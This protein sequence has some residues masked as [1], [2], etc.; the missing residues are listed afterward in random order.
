MSLN[1]SRYIY[2][3]LKHITCFPS[4][5]SPTWYYGH[6]RQ[7]CPLLLDKAH[8]AITLLRGRNGLPIS[9]DVLI[10]GMAHGCFHPSKN[11]SEAYLDWIVASMQSFASHQLIFSHFWIFAFWSLC[12]G[13][14]L[15]AAYSCRRHWWYWEVNEV[16]ILGYK[17]PKLWTHCT[18]KIG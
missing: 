15:C 16:V 4:I 3:H 13:K 14:I 6:S 8:P 18:G 9:Y 1:F 10:H 5:N 17:V 7:V 11:L 2:M 12:K